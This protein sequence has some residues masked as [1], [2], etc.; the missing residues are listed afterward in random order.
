MWR[1]GIAYA[2]LHA[3]DCVFDVS[4]GDKDIGPAVIIVVEEKTA[5]AQ[6]HQTGASNFGTWSF[7]HK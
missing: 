1:L 2:L 5:K 6:C 3:L 7:V 4:I